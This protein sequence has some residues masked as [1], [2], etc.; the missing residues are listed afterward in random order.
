MKIVIIFR[1]CYTMFAVNGMN[2]VMILHVSL[3]H[4]FFSYLGFCKEKILS[5]NLEMFF[6]CCSK[7]FIFLNRTRELLFFRW[8]ENIKTFREPKVVLLYIRFLKTYL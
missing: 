8:Q 3:L 7:F 1:I 4:L 5:V 6:R 2:F